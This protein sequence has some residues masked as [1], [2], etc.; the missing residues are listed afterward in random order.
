[1]QQFL[2]Q[3][4]EL[5]K[6]LS[7]MSDAHYSDQVLIIT[8]VLSA[9]A[10]LRWPGNR[11]DRKRYIELLAKHSEPDNHSTWVSIPALINNGT[12]LAK[13]TPCGKP[14]HSSRIFRDHEIDLEITDAA[15]KYPQVSVNDLRKFCYASLI[16][17]WLRCGYSHQYWAHPNSTYVPPSRCKARVS[18][19]T[20][21]SSNGITKMVHFHIDYLLRLAEDQVSKMTL[22]ANPKPIIWWVDSN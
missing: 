4:L 7:T 22:M 21:T 10:A 3:R 19:I 13:D 5:V 11:I 6:T 20:R 1:M 16:Y 8:A 14:G 18:Y 15:K 2:Q 9:C 12:I 17:E